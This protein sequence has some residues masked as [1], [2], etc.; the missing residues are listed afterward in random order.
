M[1]G[2][3]IVVGVDESEAG[4][5]ALVWAMEEAVTRGATVTAVN[6]WSH[7]PLSDFAFT[8]VEAVRAAST[9]LLDDAV[10]AARAKVTTAVGVRK[11]SVSGSPATRLLVASEDAALLVVGSHRGGLLRE[12]VLGSCAAACVRHA[13]VPVVVIPPPDR[14]PRKHFEIEHPIA[15]TY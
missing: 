12:I 9:E 1:N 14:L 2:N 11:V 13:T 15:P 7:E 4:R 3:E 10:T 6:V 5:A 8:S